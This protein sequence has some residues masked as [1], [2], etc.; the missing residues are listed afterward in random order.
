MMKYSLVCWFK[1]ILF[2]LISL[3]VNTNL[4]PRDDKIQ[5]ERISVPEGLSQTSV[6]CVY[7]DSRG[8]IWVGTQGGLNKYDGYRF[9]IYTHDPKNPHSVSNNI[10][11]SICED[12][13]GSIWFGTLT[14]GLNHFVREKEIFYHYTYNADNPNSLSHNR[15]FSIIED[16]RG[17]LWIG[18]RGGLNK[19]DRE[20]GRVTRYT[21]DPHNPD[22]ISHDK[23]LRL[24]EDRSGILWI[25][26][27]GGGL[28][29]LNRETGTFTCY[30]HNPDD[31]HSLSDNIIFSIYQDRKGNLWV[32]TRL[33]GLN[34]F[35]PETGKF[36]HYKNNPADP[37][38]LSNNFVWSIYE[39]S[40]GNLWVG[41]N[42]GLNRF[43]NKT[44]TF[45]RY[46][47]VTD[48][49]K[50]L[51]DNVITS[52]LED[53][54]G[55]LWIGTWG[56]GL[57]KT[58][59]KKKKFSQYQAHGN[60]PH[61][62][63]NNIIFAIYESPSEPGVMWIGTYGG[64]LNQFFRE[65]GTFAHYQHDPQNPRS[66][67]NNSVTDI[68]EDQTGALW[69]GT[70]GGG[71]NQFNRDSQQ[72]TSYQ[73]NPNN[74]SYS[75][76]D[77]VVNRLYKDRSGVL[78]VGTE[79]G[80]LYTFDHQN[81]RF[82]PF[83][84]AALGD[85]VVTS[86]HEDQTGFLWFGTQTGGVFRC[87]RETHQFDHFHSD[88]DHPESLDG[89]WVTVI[90]E[91]QSGILWIGTPEGLNKFDPIKK[92]FPNYPGKD[93]P[94][95][96]GIAGILEDNQGNLWVS[97][98]KGLA[99]FNPQTGSFRKYETKDGLQSTEFNTAACC[100]AVSGE[101]FFGGTNGFNAFFPE[102]ITDNP[103]IPP[104]VVTSFKKFNQPV[105]LPTH[106]SETKELKLSYND[107][108]IS[109]EFASLCFVNP[110]ENQYAYMLEGLTYLWIYLGNKHDITFTSLD[111]GEYRFRV[112]GS[113]IDGIWNEAGT[114]I[115]LIITPPF[116]KTSWFM[117]ISFLLFAIVSYLI[118]SFARKHL[119]L[120]TFWKKKNYIGHYRITARIG[121]GGM[122][123][124]YKAYHVMGKK[125]TKSVA[126]KV[127]REEFTT[128]EMQRKR[129]L[130]EALLID[131]LD[132]PNIV[133][134]IERGEYNNQLFLV[135]E[136]L[137]G[138]SL[139]ELIR[140]NV[141]FSIQEAAGIMNQLVDALAKIHEKGIIHRD[142]KPENIM[143][144]EKEETRYFVKLLDFGLARDQT[145]TRL[146]E[147][148]EILGTINY[149]PP[150]RISRQTLS[151][152]GDIYSLG[153]IFYE[154]LTLEKPF[155][156]ETPVDI[157]KCILEKEPLE[158][159]KF[160]PD[161]ADELNRLI[162]DMMIKEPEKRPSLEVV[163]TSIEN[164]CH[165]PSKEP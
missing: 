103:F 61:S 122:G 34:R 86:L 137:E 26:T 110:L 28:N 72:F 37:H 102:E 44:G 43:H 56:G 7:Q 5:F 74:N 27:I 11:L 96:R 13:S 149:L 47:A 50:S 112:K 162:L 124:V 106:I 71:I 111:P 16:R 73:A 114:A 53:R 98:N 95:N 140:K 151:P 45:S 116:W 55:V 81:Q 75:L 33:G 91:D 104:V 40:L 68:C 94:A 10:I 48:D 54:S 20:T 92:S 107:S 12:D 6:Y 120:I 36:I 113:N 57:S 30:M 51:S 84:A 121:S 97:C 77:N 129:F 105:Q 148:G 150:E 65:T 80:G 78:W 39:D 130:N 63:S 85:H 99:K 19:F 133:N 49:S 60:D 59:L 38:S 160:R 158:P 127:I 115:K 70:N 154:M 165:S 132:H 108:I 153:I 136:M 23:V 46:H 159:G 101:M 135:M 2:T 25:G 87:R 66:L 144:M 123:V 152:A 62:L 4:L 14:G 18:T 79:T 117:V 52:M 161:L 58:Y 29:Q 9:T 90:Y 76:K 141:K 143:V 3:A 41:T 24:F 32:G 88:Q 35:V 164:F 100:K 156:G 155:L 119:K 109:F 146:T 126:L 22:S 15:V 145:L 125:K 31:P 147:T 64:G 128:D 157:I 138:E 118:I 83:Q 69:I 139:A 82:L 163:K 93:H 1:T 131:R 134:V 21:H 42:N 142:L 8:F 89:N 17:F 67:S